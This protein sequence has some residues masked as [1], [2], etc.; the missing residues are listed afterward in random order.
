MSG[1]L[2]TSDILVVVDKGDQYSVN[3]QPPDKYGIS[4]QSGDTYVVNIDL[5][6]TIVVNEDDNYYRVADFAEFAATA[7]FIGG[8]GAAVAWDTVTNKPSGLVSS[9][10][11]VN[12]VQIQNIPVGL[13]SSSTQVDYTQLQNLPSASSTASYVE[14]DN[15]VN[16][17][18]LVSSSQQVISAI[19]GNNITPSS[20]TTNGLQL[21]TQVE[22]TIISSS[23]KS[24]IFNATEVFDP[25]FPADDFSGVL[26]EYV[27][28]REM[29]VRTGILYASWSGSSITYTD[30]SNTDVGDTTDLSFNFAR[31]NGDVV[32]RAYSLGTGAGAWSV[33]CLF[34]MFPNL[35]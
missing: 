9:S 1:S 27:A 16:K 31:I 18:T 5:P 14:Y 29:A 28:Q 35:L 13:V 7:S 4:I 26:V 21:T 23:R 33:Q 34:K 19:S 22:P 17:P 3:V 10:T 20:I 6:T 15:V 25:T 8:F 30:V 24:G 2:D 11:Q 32:L 12:Y